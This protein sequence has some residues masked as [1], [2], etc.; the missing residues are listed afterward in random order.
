M[1]YEL[2]LRYAITKVSARPKVDYFAQLFDEQKAFA[3]DTS[4]FRAAICTRRAGKSELAA[5]LLA[6][7]AQ[8]HPGSISLYIAL[9]RDSA[10]SILW[11]ILVKMNED[12]ELGWTMLEGSLIVVTAEGSIIRLVGADMKNFINRLRGPKYAIAIIDEAQSFGSHLKEL[13]DDVLEPALMDLQGPLC[14]FGT[15]GPTPFGY[16]FEVTE[17]RKHGFS[18]HKWSLL[19]NP[20]LPHAKDFIEKLLERK[21][22]T[23][24]NPT[25][26]REW[27]GEWVLDVDALFYKYLEGRND[28]K[29]LPQNIELTNVMAIDYGFNDETAFGIVTYSKDSPKTFI[30]HVEGHRGMIPT[31]IAGRIRQLMDTYKPTR[32]IADT[33]GLG[34]SI[35]EEMKIRYGLPIFPADKREKLTNVHLMN[36][37]FIDGNCL[38]HESLSR[39][40]EQYKTLTRTDDGFETPG[41]P[42]DLCD[43]S[44]YGW[45]LARGYSFRPKEVLDDAAKLRREEE[46]MMAAAVRQAI[47]APEREWWENI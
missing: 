7:A 13:V 40:T 11:P 26:R 36:G 38:V 20:F 30:R 5:R 25:Y 46:Q 12:Y 35:T 4:S 28:F 2:L 8:K 19:Q 6:H 41:I 10:E 31:V 42:N 39:L 37:D 9:T 23:H 16:F 15:P 32:I 43:V 17:K 29:E 14:L 33:G 44:L 24:D 47:G 27:L 18:L 1:D 34:K 21:G 22:W 45:K 3:F